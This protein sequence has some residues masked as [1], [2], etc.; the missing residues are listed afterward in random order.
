MI[1]LIRKRYTE[2]TVYSSLRTEFRLVLVVYYI[3]C[4]GFVIYFF[5]LV[6]T[7]HIVSA[8]PMLHTVLFHIVFVMPVVTLVTVCRYRKGYLKATEIKEEL[9][10]KASSLSSIEVVL[11]DNPMKYEF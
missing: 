11:L 9:T 7:M 3:P 4:L 5:D 8:E 10:T 1:V 6:L 2:P